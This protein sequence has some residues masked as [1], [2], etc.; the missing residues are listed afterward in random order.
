MRRTLVHILVTILMA[1]ATSVQARLGYT[2]EQCDQQYG[3]PID[4][5]KVNWGYRYTYVIN[6]IRIEASFSTGRSVVDNIKYSISGAFTEGQIT[7]ILGFSGE[8]GTWRVLNT[9]P[10]EWASIGS[11]LLK[12]YRSSKGGDASLFSKEYG[13]SQLLQIRSSYD[14]SEEQKITRQREQQELDK[15][16]R[17]TDG[18]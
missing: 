16:R 9:R 3:K 5:L 2:K 15:A 4:S 12:E 1:S 6:D 10:I 11:A 7:T 8:G 13:A 14:V 17:Q 18:L